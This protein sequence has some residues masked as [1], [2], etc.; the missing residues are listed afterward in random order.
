[1]RETRKHERSREVLACRGPICDTFGVVSTPRRLTA[2]AVV[3]GALAAGSG[4][5]ACSKSTSAGGTA[6]LPTAPPTTAD[7]WAVPATITPDY[8]NRV[9]ASLDHDEG[10][11]LRL[12]RHDNALGP[13]FMA[14]EK[15]IRPSGH[16]LQI[17][18]DLETKSIAAG[19]PNTKLVPGDRR[20]TVQRLIKADHAC[21]EAATAE[22]YS[23]VTAG[24][25][26]P[27][28]QWY[29][30]LIPSPVTGSNPTH[31]AY[32]YDGYESTGIVPSSACDAQ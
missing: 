32:S 26:S 28:P 15:S 21:I 17:E 7:P 9:L 29:V 13:E 11:A 3:I 30:G 22:D 20:S 5:P 4:L 8:V 18:V 19:W 27:Y 14:I 31:W 12:A 24:T 10:Q 6:T 16:E 1:M 25:P 2:S 23:A